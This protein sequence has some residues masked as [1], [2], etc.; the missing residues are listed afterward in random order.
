MKNNNPEVTRIDGIDYSI[1]NHGFVYRKDGK[2]WVRSSI[3]PTKLVKAKRD[4]E[5]RELKAEIAKEKAKIRLKKIDRAKLIER[6][7][8]KHAARAKARAAA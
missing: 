7:A 1:R 4:Q 2:D 6:L 3:T 5:L 8:A